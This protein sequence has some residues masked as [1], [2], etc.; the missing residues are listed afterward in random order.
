M[1]HTKLTGLFLALL[2][3]AGLLSGCAETPE[4]P[5]VKQKGEAALGDYQ[6]AEPVQPGV[7]LREIIDAPERYKSEIAGADGK[8]Q[9]STDAVVEMPDADKVPAVYVKQHP[10]EQEEID[11]ITKAVF[12]DVDVYDASSYMEKTKSEWQTVI[13]ELKGY[14]AAGNLDPFGYGQDENGNYVYDLYGEIE[15]AE[16]EY[17]KAQEN[18]ELVKLE[19]PYPFQT[20]QFSLGFDG[21]EKE[22]SEINGFVKIQDGN[23]YLY[24][25]IKGIGRPMNVQ[26]KKVS[27][28]NHLD[29]TVM[30][31][32]YDSMKLLYSWVPDEETLAG[33]I[34]I[35]MEEARKLAD[36]KIAKLEIP[37]MEVTAS[38]I[39]L[40]LDLTHG[41]NIPQREDM[42]KTGYAFHYTRK[43]DGIPITYTMIPGGATEG[44]EE[45][46]REAWC[47]EALDVYVSK[48]GIEEINFVNRYDIGE[49]KVENLELLSF[50]D[51]MSIYEKMIVVQNADSLVDTRE[52]GEDRVAP[53]L[54]RSYEID[55][56]TFGYTRIYD[57]QSNDQTG[58]LVPVWDFFG[59]EGIADSEAGISWSDDVNKSFLTINAVDGSIIN[60]WLGY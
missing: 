10:F 46:V 21:D 41:H 54:N 47:Y 39:V 35:S 59:K 19:S 14:E 1:R 12:G 3:G 26:I 51:I 8:L 5:I 56:I 48:D 11:Q 58:L 27:D 34:G 6:E 13:E 18:R 53:S 45:N 32:E 29:E 57:P 22:Y 50:D 33:E 43:L 40:A 60:R 17:K 25:I 49:T 42:T 7:S 30:W 28:E 16:M 23:C 2:V 37:G 4:S 36:E 9:V 55:R 20:R 31:S 52:E 24:N 15:K 44:G 38:E